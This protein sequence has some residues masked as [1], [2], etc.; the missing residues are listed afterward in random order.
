MANI[1]SIRV[2][3]LKKEHPKIAANGD[4]IV[5]EGF[6]VRFTLFKTAKGMFVGLPGRYGDNSGENGKKPWY[7]DVA[8]VDD[9]VRNEL[10]ERVIAEYNK[11]TGGAQMDQG[12]APE[13]TNQSNIPF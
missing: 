10:T 2:W 3:P 7:A 13:P 12:E 6:K 11:A 5:D 4:F 1:T 8:F 9:A